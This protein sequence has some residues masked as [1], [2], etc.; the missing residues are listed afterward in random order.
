METEG[1][2]IFD[3]DHT[4]TRTSTA[5]SYLILMIKKKLVPIS[6]LSSVPYVYLNYKFGKMNEKHFDRK[7]PEMIG[8]EKELFDNLA[9][10]N[11]DRYIKKSIYPK[12]FEYIKQLK[13]DGKKVLFASSSMELVLKPLVDYLN[14]DDLIATR[15]DFQDGKCTGRF[16]DSPVFKNEKKRKV[17]EY[18][19]TRNIELEKSSFYSDSI[20]DLPLLEA[21]GRPVAANPDIR[22][23]LTAGKRGWKIINFR[24]K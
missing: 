1:I 11:F 2:E 9:I 21:V 7:V 24:E 12:A 14:A 16:I 6:L 17:L 20:H 10:E 4:I 5:I 15:V 19:S 8:L 22:L 18:I 23:K 3:V 13:D